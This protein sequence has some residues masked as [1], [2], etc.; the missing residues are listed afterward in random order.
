MAF[1]KQFVG[2]SY[3]PYVMDVFLVYGYNP[4]EA[5][6]LYEEIMELANKEMSSV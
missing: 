1:A 5:S 2:I 6:G 3:S 4:E